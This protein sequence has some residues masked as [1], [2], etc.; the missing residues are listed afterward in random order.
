MII[1]SELIRR[2]IKI[3]S[4]IKYTYELI[5]SRGN[6][7]SSYGLPLYSVNVKMKLGEKTFEKSSGKLFADR[8]KAMR[9]FEK[10][11]RGVATPSNLPYII[12][13]EFSPL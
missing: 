8:E 7:T 10:I 13:D 1:G 4:D 2:E 5:L 12:E 3:E 11:V 9:F 6:D